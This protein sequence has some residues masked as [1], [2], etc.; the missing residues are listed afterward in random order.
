MVFGSILKFFRKSRNTPD[1]ELL[2]EVIKEATKW[3]GVHEIKGRPGASVNV[4]R[5]ATDGVAEGEPWCAAFVQYCVSAVSI[6]YGVEI[7]LYPSELCYT[8]WQNTPKRFRLEEPIPGSIV[9]WNYPGTTRGHTGIVLGG[10]GN[11]NSI[12]TIEGNTQDPRAGVDQ[13]IR[14]VFPKIRCL[15]GSE[16]MVIL[17]FINPFMPR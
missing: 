4:F 1:L 5:K 16:D 2:K 15:K 8:M 17:G 9:I 14:G 3:V 6:R 7:A 10:W 12:K 13:G 11:P